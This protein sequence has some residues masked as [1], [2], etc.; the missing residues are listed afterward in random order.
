MSLNIDIRTRAIAAVDA[1]IATIA[2]VAKMF[3][4]RRTYY[5]EIF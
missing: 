1:K 2:I 4:R 3:S 5:S